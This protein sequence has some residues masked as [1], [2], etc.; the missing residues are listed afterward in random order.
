MGTQPKICRAIEQI[1]PV[2]KLFGNTQNI[3]L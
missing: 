3:F 1:I 2:I